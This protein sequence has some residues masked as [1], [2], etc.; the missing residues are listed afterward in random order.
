MF[1]PKAEAR[2]R[3]KTFAVD[4]GIDQTVKVHHVMVP[5]GEPTVDRGQVF[6]EERRRF[7][8]RAPSQ[9]HGTLRLALRPS[10]AS[11]YVDDEFRG[12]GRQ[13]G[14]AA[15]AFPGIA[16]WNVDEHDF[17]AGQLRDPRK[18]VLVPRIGKLDLDRLEARPGRGIEALGK[19]DFLEQ[20][21]DVGAEPRHGPGLGRNP[22]AGAGLRATGR[23]SIGRFTATE[24]TDSP[25]AISHTSW[26]EPVRSKR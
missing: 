5:A 7:E 16:G 11:V 4:L 19:L 24:I 9:D 21:A 14:D 15:I 23:S 25:I 10:N 20:H 12:S 6:E 17:D 1:R 13:A 22:Q 18:P 26:Y 3:T 2:Y 8:E